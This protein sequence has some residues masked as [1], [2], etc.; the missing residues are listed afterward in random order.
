M[1]NHRASIKILSSDLVVV[2]FLHPSFGHWLESAKDHIEGFAFQN[3]SSDGKGD[4]SVSGLN[5]D[6][7][8]VWRLQ[9]ILLWGAELP[10]TRMTVPNVLR[11]ICFLSAAAAAP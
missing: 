7:L 4:R 11:I 10:L 8:Q 3:R 1:A 6:R 2:R 5:L 9:A